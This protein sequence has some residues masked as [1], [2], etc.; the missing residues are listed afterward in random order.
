MTGD[1]KLQALRQA[2]QFSWPIRQGPWQA[3]PQ[4]LRQFCAKLKEKG[5]RELLA[6]RRP[7]S[8]ELLTW[9]SL[10]AFPLANKGKLATCF[11]PSGLQ[12]DFFRPR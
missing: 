2:I 4:R 11:H 6:G 8:G 7:L 12:R 10:R 9:C 1:K 3:S 5:Q